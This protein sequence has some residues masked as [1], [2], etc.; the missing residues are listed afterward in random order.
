M[1]TQRSLIDYKP[2]LGPLSNTRAQR[3]E[4]SGPEHLQI[5]VY[6]GKT[7]SGSQPCQRVSQT[8][9]LIIVRGGTELKS[10]VDKNT[11]SL[12]EACS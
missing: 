5:G 10:K 2:E 12:V 7:T 11:S 9:T 6:I 1:Q 3:V 8:L 4:D